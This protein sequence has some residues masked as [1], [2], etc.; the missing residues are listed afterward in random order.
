MQPVGIIDERQEV[1]RKLFISMM[2][3]PTV[4]LIIRIW[5]CLLI[6]ESSMSGAQ[7]SR[8]WWDDWTVIVAAGLN[9]TVCTIGIE[10]IRLGLGLH[11]D[12]VPE[13]DVELFLKLLWIIYFVFH[14]G[15]R[16]S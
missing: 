1:L 5:N 9:I 16:H 7:M 10:T 13:P 11:I 6:P 12:E 2:V 15:C 14:H 4:M 3:I 8:F